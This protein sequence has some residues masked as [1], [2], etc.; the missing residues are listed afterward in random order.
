MSELQTFFIDWDKAPLV[1]APKGYIIKK[2]KNGLG[3]CEHM[4]VTC[5]KTGR[6]VQSEG[7]IKSERKTQDALI[8]ELESKD[9]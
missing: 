4:T 7:E 3:I 5:E 2:Y 8:K 9:D 6:Y 1:G